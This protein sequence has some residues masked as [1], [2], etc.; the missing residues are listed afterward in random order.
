MQATLQSFDA[1]DA[2]DPCIPQR[3]CFTWSARS[4]DPHAIPTG[5]S[6]GPGAEAD[7][8]ASGPG[9]SGWSATMPPSKRKDMF[10]VIAIGIASSLLLISA[11]DILHG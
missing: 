3:L 2:N 8:P 1:A 7:L 6:G 9:T 11:F 5:G 10:R 4:I